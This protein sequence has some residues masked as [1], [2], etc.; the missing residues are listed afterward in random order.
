MVS[1]QGLSWPKLCQSTFQGHQLWKWF[2]WLVERADCK[3]SGT[4]PSNYIRLESWPWSWWWKVHSRN[5]ASAVGSLIITDLT[6]ILSK[7]R[8]FFLSFDY[9]NTSLSMVNFYKVPQN[10][11]KEI[12]STIIIP[13]QYNNFWCFS[14]FFLCYFNTFKTLIYVIHHRV[15][16]TDGYK[17]ERDLAMQI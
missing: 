12:K 8:F 5:S 17:I 7:T 16:L 14:P 6:S 4:S 9:E 11:K 15:Y 2:L 10:S 1:H 13:C 3:S